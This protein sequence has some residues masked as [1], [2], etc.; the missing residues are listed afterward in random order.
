[1]IEFLGRACSESS[2]GTGAKS[3]VSSRAG[4]AAVYA[5]LW[6]I[7]GVLLAVPITAVLKILFE[8]TGF[9]DP[10]VT[11]MSARPNSI[12]GGSETTGSA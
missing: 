4:C 5:A 9:L 1:M 6:G 3:G 11:L 2:K 7:I 8:K 10:V 12:G